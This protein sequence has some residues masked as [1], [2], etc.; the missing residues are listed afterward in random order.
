MTEGNPLR[1]PRKN[2]PEQ[3]AQRRDILRAL[4]HWSAE[5]DFIFE[6]PGPGGDATYANA[7]EAQTGSMVW[8]V[9]V[10]GP[11][12]VQYG[13][14]AFED[15][16]L[17]ESGRQE[18]AFYLPLAETEGG[19]AASMQR[20]I[21]ATSLSGGIRTFLLDD[22]IT[23][24]SAFLL[25]STQEAVALARWVQA[26]EQEMHDWLQDPPPSWQK[27][28][29]NG[30]API[31][32]HAELLAVRPFVLGDTCHLLYQFSTGDAV[33]ANLATRNAY[34]L[35]EGFVVPRFRSQTGIEPEEWYL[36]MNMGGDK[37]VSYLYFI[38]G[39]HG[40]VAEAEA[41]L[42]PNVLSRVLHIT[43]QQLDRV[44]HVGL[45]GAIS[46]G[47]VSS[48]FTPA[49]AVAAIYAAT[50]QDLGMV[51]TSSMCQTTSRNL[52]DGSVH[53]GV[54]MPSIEVGTIGGGTTLPY[55]RA[56]LR[57][58]DCAG[59]GKAQQF[60]QLVAAAVLCLEISAIASMSVAG[61]ANFYEAHLTRGGLR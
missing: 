5:D 13:T 29:P 42:T 15:R 26:H 59:A 55:A 54:R 58:M 23:R 38:E 17:R 53:F 60:A 49:T 7:L 28:R 43:P 31:S 50:G 39:G 34:V 57:L 24:D 56:Y 12:Q 3:I 30:V 8:P 22:R 52:P 35:N 33:G 37:K 36:E 14:Y 40:K 48:A 41:T 45:Q 19:L 16:H 6:T 4:P 10:C 2:K 47:M 1:W 18:G 46:S 61:S 32:R 44:A 25:H 27:Q 9:A 11:M 51:G 20:G 21:I